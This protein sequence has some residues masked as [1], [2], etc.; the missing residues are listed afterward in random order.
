MNENEKIKIFIADN[1]DETTSEIIEYFENNKRY[2]IVNSCKDGKTALAELENTPVDVLITDIVLAG[3]DGFV[4]MEN[5]KE[6]LFNKRDFGW[7]NIDSN[8]NE[9][10]AEN[11]KTNIVEELLAGNYENDED[12]E[13]TEETSNEHLEEYNIKQEYDIVLDPKETEYIIYYRKK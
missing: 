9:Y 7:K 13:N 4:L 11:E 8:E 10:L 6:K 2:E 12:Y 5:L 3:S 1:S